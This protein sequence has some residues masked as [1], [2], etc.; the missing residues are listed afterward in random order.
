MQRNSID[1]LL[2]VS[3]R[4]LGTRSLTTKDIVNGDRVQNFR[5]PSRKAAD[6]AGSFG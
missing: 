5:W 1:A 2:L 6:R 3:N 4:I